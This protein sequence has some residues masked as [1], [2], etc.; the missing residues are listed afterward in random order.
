MENTELHGQKLAI[1]SRLI[2]ESSLTLE[3]ALVLLQ[4]EPNTEAVEPNMVISP[5]T[6]QPTIYPNW[7]GTTPGTIRFGSSSTNVGI[8]TINPSTTLAVNNTA[9]ADLNN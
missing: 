8:G 1:L 7:G 6:S 9:V 4:D 3:E 2:K 5:W